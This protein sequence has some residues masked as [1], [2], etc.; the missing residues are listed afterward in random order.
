MCSPLCMMTTGQFGSTAQG[1][2]PIFHPLAL[3]PAP[4][5]H[6]GPPTGPRPAAGP[7]GCRNDIAKAL[8]AVPFCWCARP[9]ASP[10]ACSA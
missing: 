5:A 2:A 7:A 1:A 3:W 4:P 8:S 9:P 10:P 6:L